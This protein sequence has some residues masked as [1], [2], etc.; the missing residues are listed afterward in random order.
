MVLLFAANL[1]SRSIS[2]K[3][4]ATQARVAQATRTTADGEQIY[5]ASYCTL[6]VAEQARLL[7]EVA[8]ISGVKFERSVRSLKSDQAS[9]R[10]LSLFVVRNVRELDLEWPV[11]NS[12]YIAYIHVSM[13]IVLYLYILKI[14]KEREREI[15]YEIQCLDYTT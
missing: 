5:H 6:Y 15:M 10:V 12:K 4:D 14:R 2:L 13:I 1:R 11:I 8:I 9:S 7:V 3:V